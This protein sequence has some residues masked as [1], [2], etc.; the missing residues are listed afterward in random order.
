MKYGLFSIIPTLYDDEEACQWIDCSVIKE[1]NPYVFVGYD[2]G[3]YSQEDYY[4]K[5]REYIYKYVYGNDSITQTMKK[6]N[7]LKK[8]YNLS[9]KTNDSSTGLTIFIIIC[10]SLLSMIVLLIIFYFKNDM[11]YSF[12]PNEF[13]II[14]LLG[15]I[16]I[17]CT[18]FTLY[19]ELTVTKCF[20]K[21]IFFNTTYL[22]NIV[23]IFIQLI[24]N[25]PEENK[26][27][28]WFNKRFNRYLVLIIFLIIN[29]ILVGLM[30]INP[31]SIETVLINDGENY[32][33]CV[34]NN[35]F[36]IVLS[37][38]IYSIEIIIL[39][40]SLFLLFIEWNLIESV[41]HSRLITSL[42]FIDLLLLII[43]ECFHYIKFKN[44][45]IDGI[46]LYFIF[47]FLSLT[48]FILIF[49]TKIYTILT[50]RNSIENMIVV[51]K[52]NKRQFSPSNSTNITTGEVTGL[53][54]ENN[55]KSTKYS[56]VGLIMKYHYQESKTKSHYQ[57]SKM[58]SYYQESKSEN[59]HVTN[60]YENN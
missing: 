56:S 49:I 50:N 26:I 11:K 44:Y 13:W 38:L 40:L 37:K 45:I 8:K 10:I 54:E 32:Q 47:F 60:I 21:L 59:Y 52:N 53:S 16:F 31:Y 43:Y 35:V 42:V 46:S 17:Q 3:D 14:S 24:V 20:S 51:L 25:F 33:I 39:I 36:S 34:L 7:D 41:Y 23:P 57:E 27:S 22:I 58:D 30:F 4:N 19:G 29:Y 18:I 1:A 9:I 6:L 2:T 55:I 15:S 5:I 12:L 28:D 48:N